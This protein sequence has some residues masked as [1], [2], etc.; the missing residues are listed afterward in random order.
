M[1]TILFFCGFLAFI[2]SSSTDKLIFVSLHSRHG[3]RA[4]LDCDEKQLDFLGENWTN[5]GELTPTGQR[6]EYLLGLRNRQRYIKISKFLSPKFDP[7]EILV[8]STNVNRTILSMAS[9]LQGLYPMYNKSGYTLTEDQIK[10][11]KPP[12]DVE[13]EDIKKEIENLE[14]AALPNYMTI[15]PIH[16]LITSERKMNV[17]DS[18]G[19]KEKVN[20]TRDNNKVNNKKVVDEANKFNEKYA[21]NLNKYYDKNP[22]NFT[23]DFDWIGLFCDTVISDYSDGRKM[24][25]FFERTTI[26]KDELINDC[27]H[28]IYTNFKEDFFGDEKNEVILLGISNKMKEVLHYMQLKID[29]DMYNNEWTI[30]NVVD[31]SKPK[32]V[33]YSG[34][35]S[36]LT[37]EELFMIKYFNKKDEDFFYPTYTTQLAFEV[38]RDEEKPDY[39]D[40]SSYQVTFYVNDDEFVVTTFQEFKDIVEKTVWSEEQISEFCED[41]IEEKNEGKIEDNSSTSNSKIQLYAI[42]GLACLSLI[43]II[44]I[45]CLAVK[46]CKMNNNEE[47]NSPGNEGL[48]NEDEN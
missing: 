23:Y 34:H 40:Y 19:C 30:Q 8:Y 22:D 44:I 24:E 37:A 41:K 26:D 6:M 45:I 12:V 48:V 15:I 28:V 2:N 39:L 43:F 4:P 29:E 5:P 42:V 36:T 3:A 47:V 21:K 20:K 10:V 46:L 13:Y 35:D 38:T 31:Y 18:T 33:I 17:Q 7:H 16:T 27:K 32:M 25:N 9:Q 11:S 1:L 14:E